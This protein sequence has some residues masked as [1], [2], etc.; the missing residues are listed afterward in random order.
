MSRKDR[1]EITEIFMAKAG[2]DWNRCFHGT[3]R[4]ERDENGTPIVYGK[5]KVN[6]CVIYASAP[7]QWELGDKLDDMVLLILD[8]DLHKRIGS[9]FWTQ[10]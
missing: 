9:S 8:Y 3:I 6:D 7:D 4:R 10:N 2:N 5:I 1:F